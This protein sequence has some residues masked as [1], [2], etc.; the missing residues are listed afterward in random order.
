[1]LFV[2]EDPRTM[3]DGAWLEVVRGRVDRDASRGGATSAA[4]PPPLLFWE[5]ISARHD[6]PRDG[7]VIPSELLGPGPAAGWR[8]A[9]LFR[10]GNAAFAD[11]HADSID[12]D[13][14]LQP[15][16]VMP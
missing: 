12:R 16:N 6:L 5:P 14:T 1:M 3:E 4:W 9:F 2:E 13:Y 10:R 15:R 7:D 8:G 11:G